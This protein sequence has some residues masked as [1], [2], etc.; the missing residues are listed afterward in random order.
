MNWKSLAL[1]STSIV[2]LG[3]SATASHAAPP[4]MG[5]VEFGVTQWFD[6]YRYPS[7]SY[8]YD[9]ASIDGAARVNIPYNQ[10]TNIQLD[11]SADGSLQGSGGEGQS[12]V[13]T[14]VMGAHF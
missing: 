1:V 7:N 6:T 14:A 9:W 12:A 5:E 4:A 3:F 2:A 11:F 10:W 13:G 8:D